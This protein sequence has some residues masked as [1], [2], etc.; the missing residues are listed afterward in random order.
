MIRRFFRGLTLGGVFLMGMVLFRCVDQL[1][2]EYQPKTYTPSR[3]I[4]D[5]C[6]YISRDT[7][8]TDTVDI[9][10]TDDDTT[11][12]IETDTLHYPIDSRAFEQIVTSDWIDT[13]REEVVDYLSVSSDSSTGYLLDTLFAA[14]HDA[15]IHL[16]PDMLMEQLNSVQTDTTLII[17]N[18]AGYDTSYVVYRQGSVSSGLFHVYLSWEFAANNLDDFIEV[19]FFG[20]NGESIQMS[21]QYDAVSISGCGEHVIFEAENIDRIVPKIQTSATVETTDGEYL[22]R[23]IVSS[24]SEIRIIRGLLSA[25]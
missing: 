16:F 4:T 12:I 23:L 10:I 11:Y 22:I 15:I 7:I 21:P 9:E 20:T 8:S 14:G 2:N 19:E 25:Q 17:H 1:P 18:P 3:D 6:Y 24:P 13:R 5:A